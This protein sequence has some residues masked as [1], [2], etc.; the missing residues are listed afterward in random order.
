MLQLTHYRIVIQPLSSLQVVIKKIREVVRAVT[1]AKVEGVTVKRTE[2]E[3]E[4]EEEEEKVVKMTK[5]RVTAK[6]EKEAAEEAVEVE[7]TTKQ[8]LKQNKKQRL[9]KH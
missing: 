7:E 8:R 9:P 2:E 4:T 5:V 1:E 6:E 3:K